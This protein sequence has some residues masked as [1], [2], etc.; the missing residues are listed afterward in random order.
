MKKSN[1]WYH[2]WSPTLGD[3][4]DKPEKIWG[5][6]P[7]D[8]EKHRDEK[9]VFCGLYGLPDFYALWRHR[10]MKEVWWCGTDILHFENGYWLEDGGKHSFSNIGKHDL[11][12]WLSRNCGH[13]VENE[14]ERDR[15]WKSGILARIQP[16][17]LGDVK[18]FKI[19]FRPGNK[20]YTS[21]SGND[22][23]RYGWDKIPILAS[24]NP[25]IEFYLYGN[26][27]TPP[28]RFPDNVKLRGRVSKEQMNKEIKKM[29]GGLRLTD[30]DGFSEII[31]KSVLMGQ[32]PISLI[33]YPYTLTPDK[34]GN[35]VNFTHPNTEGRDYYL[36]NL[37]QY[38]WA[39]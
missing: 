22:F 34:I 7:Y 5:T 37:N 33:P 36:K 27:I 23:E 39:R 14:V 18:K 13:W 16:S 24:S 17:F 25:N 29:Q 11:A 21:V 26:T 4:E 10:G 28:Y 1:Q 9:V 30:F 20:V 32:Y 38:P 12:V 6:L 35:I 31:A 19:S 2:R 8:P 3:L 15:L